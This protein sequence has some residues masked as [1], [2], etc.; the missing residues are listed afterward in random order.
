MKVVIYSRKS[1]FTSKGESIENQVELC[2]RYILA[3]LPEVAEEDVTVFEDEGFSAK[4]T[5]RPQFQQMLTRI[6]RKEFQ[7]LVCYRLDRVSRSVGDCSRLIEELRDLD[8]SFISVTERFDTTT[9]MGKAM[10][11]V[12][13]VFA[14]LE[15]ETLAER[16]RDNMFMLARTGRWLGGTTP[17]GFVS[18]KTEKVDVDGKKRT[19]C[20]LKHDPEEIK[21]VRIIFQ[22][23]LELHSVSGV[24]KYLAEAGIRSRSGSWYSKIG[25][26][27]ILQNPVYCAA[28]KD[29]RDYFVAQGS[30]ICFPETDC[31]EEY[32]LLAYNKRDY[33]KKNAPRQ[34]VSEWIIAMGKHRGIVTGRQWVAIQEILNANRPASAGTNT[35]NDYCLLSGLILCGKCGRRMFSRLRRN[36]GTDGVYDYICDGKLQGGKKVCDCRNLNGQQTDD[37]VCDYL[38]QYADKGSDLHRRLERLADTLKRQQKANPIA[39]LD[40]R[41]ARCNGQISSLV[42]QLSQPGTGQTL[43]ARINAKVEELTGELEQLT[44]QKKQLEESQDRIAG[45]EQDLELVASLLSSFRRYFPE[46]TLQEKRSLIRLLVQKIVWDGEDLHI[47]IY[48][49]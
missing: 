22:K 45:Q 48:G 13:S 16:V 28:D 11:M 12:A 27:Q 20:K 26:K 9:P 10:L 37:M 29:A 14:Q 43:L 7:C 3:N 35:F 25:I 31:S 19:A 24:Y 1:V 44:A 17:T 21:T 49:E 8:V 47:F 39:E 2:R 23:F 33:K 18:E 34:D 42:D 46:M 32:G 38:M 6:R 36:K 5:K 40:A 41:I 4:D 15:R 30:D